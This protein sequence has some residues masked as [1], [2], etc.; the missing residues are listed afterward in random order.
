MKI[1]T[2][3]LFTITLLFSDVYYSKVEP[4]KIRK[5]SSNVSG[6]ITVVDEDMLGKI[7]SNKPYIKIDN[8]LDI[9]ELN[10]IKEKL[11]DSK[12]I[13]LLDYKILK[14]IN[15]LLLKKRENY[16]KIKNLKIKSIFEKNKEFY[17]LIASENLYL[18]TKKEINTLKIQISDLELRKTQLIKNI[19]DK[20]LTAKGFVLYTLDVK[21]G[22]FVNKSTP[23]ATLVD[24]SKAILTI[25]LNQDDALVAK[26][27]TIY[28]N[29]KKTSYKIDRLL[30]IAD[31]KN[32][33]KYMAQIIIKSPKLFSK[34]LKIEL[35]SDNNEK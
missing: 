34:L 13:L 18:S 14:N 4:Y 10:A 23:L 21:V 12:Q 17:D 9:D 31:S 19:N 35:R 6:L 15:E 33:S 22:Q 8:V 24:T 27:K 7:L 5:I 30:N 16:K 2:L 1:F 11:F 25:Y 3:L 20:N 28:I 32:I 26:N 29:D